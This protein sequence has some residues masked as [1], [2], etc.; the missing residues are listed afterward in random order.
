MTGWAVQQ[1]HCDSVN[2]RRLTWTTQTYKHTLT[3]FS[4]PCLNSRG[5]RHLQ[6]ASSLL[7]GRCVSNARY[8]VWKWSRLH[9]QTFLWMLL[10][11]A[12]CSVSL[13]VSS[14]GMRVVLNILSHWAAHRGMTVPGIRL[15]ETERR[16]RRRGHVEKNRRKPWKK[17]RA[18]EKEGI[19]IFFLRV[20]GKQGGK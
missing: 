18:R 8:D 2:Q 6:Y 1:R 14:P 20:R 16:R 9:I 11:R 12:C 17:R 4:I 15:W 13:P 19:F 10:T 7:K 5:F 3:Q